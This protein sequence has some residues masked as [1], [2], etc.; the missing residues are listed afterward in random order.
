MQFWPTDWVP[1]S[2][3]RPDPFRHLLP[4]DA[5]VCFTHADLHLQNI[6]VSDDQESRCVVAIVDWGQAGWYPEYWEY[7]KAT[8]MTADHEWC[9]DGWLMQTM[10]PYDEEL[11]AVAYYWNCRPP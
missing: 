11:D 10:L 1:L 2:E 6:L 9:K 3:R 7:C 5:A 8:L 4:D